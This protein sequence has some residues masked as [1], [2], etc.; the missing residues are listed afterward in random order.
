MTPGYIRW[1]ELA[2]AEEGSES[3]HGSD[4]SG[5]LQWPAGPCARVH[6]WGFLCTVPLPSLPTQ[7]DRVKGQDWPSQ[8]DLSLSPSFSISAWEFNNFW[9]K[10]EENLA[11]R[12]EDLAEAVR[13]A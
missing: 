7:W 10:A 6:F 2:H 13:Q 12:T 5:R 8:V 3:V 4:T 9:S 1:E 11:G